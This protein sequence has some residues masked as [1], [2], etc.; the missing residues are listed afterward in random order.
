MQEEEEE[1]GERRQ[2]VRAVK[3]KVNDIRQL[4]HER[5]I[6]LNEGEGVAGWD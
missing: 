3:K 4:Q 5:E 1:E 2:K 6:K